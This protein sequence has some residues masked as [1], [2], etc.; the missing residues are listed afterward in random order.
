M[1]QGVI[2]AIKKL[3]EQGYRL[4]TASIEH[5]S[6]LKGYLRGMRVKECF[7]NFYGPDLIN[8]HKTSEIFYD[9]IFKHIGIEY[10]KAIILDDDPRFLKNAK[11]LKLMLSKHV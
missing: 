6:E 4:Y 5:S 9:R 11:N 3:H 10:R 1:F 7:T 8:I 2:E